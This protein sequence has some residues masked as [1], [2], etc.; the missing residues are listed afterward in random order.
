MPGNP[1]RIVGI[2]FGAIAT[3]LGVTFILSGLFAIVAHFSGK[4][5]KVEPGKLLAITTVF[6]L[7]GT[8]ALYMGIRM[9]KRPNIQAS[10]RFKPTPRAL[11]RHGLGLILVGGFSLVYGLFIKGWIVWLPVIAG[12]LSIACGV[13]YLIYSKPRAS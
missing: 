2:A 6:L 9:L 7:L 10:S 11:V 4:G 5:A 13:I 8:S 1:S 12:A 3:L